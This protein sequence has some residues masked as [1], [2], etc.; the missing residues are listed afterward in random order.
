[1]NHDL[2]PEGSEASEALLFYANAARALGGPYDFTLEFAYLR[3]DLTAADDATP[4]CRIAMSHGLA[5][6]LV[7]R[8]VDVITTYESRYGI[9]PSPEFTGREE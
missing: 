3:P 8:M 4:V 5:K 9:A 1:V 7:P 6:A 2:S